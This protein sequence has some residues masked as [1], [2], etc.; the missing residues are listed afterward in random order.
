MATNGFI[1]VSAV[2]RVAV[3]RL[4]RTE[5][6]NALSGALLA[7]LG[8]AASHACTAGA[9]VLVI[10]GGASAFSAGADLGE[11]VALTPSQRCERNRL[12]QATFDAIELLPVPTIA[13]IDGIALGGGLELALACTMRVATARAEM[14][15]PEI[16]LGVIPTYGGT[17]R[18][19]AVVGEARATELILTGRRIDACEAERIGL[20]TRIVDD[21][22][23]GSAVTLAQELAGYS[24]AA[25]SLA[26]EAVRAGRL[27]GEG[28]RRAAERRICD[29]A[30]TTQDAAEGIRAFVERRAP[31]FRD[32]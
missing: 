15:F 26:R 28:A 2:G 20:V 8:R 9:R 14:G 4:D 31:K 7:E 18:L 21:P 19:A 16:R 3:L 13:A 25:L 32:R 6:R 10:G 24:L 29:A 1:D 22:V 5:K 27:S 23:E 11:V 12:G 17:R 30:V